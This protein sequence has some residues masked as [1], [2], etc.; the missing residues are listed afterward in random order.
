VKLAERVVA[1]HLQAG[2]KGVN[3]MPDD[4]YIQVL[5]YGT[6]VEFVLKD[7]KAPKNREIGHVRIRPVGGCDGALEAMNIAAKHGWGPFLHDIALEYAGER[8]VVPDRGSVTPEAQRLYQVYQKRGDI[9]KYYLPEMYDENECGGYYEDYWSG[10]GDY[11]ILD[12][13]YVKKT[14]TT[15]PKLKQLGKWRKS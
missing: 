9:L 12:Y 13:K 15:I 10:G 6:G 11:N 1:R 7:A 3:D 4:W 5:K 2:A 8:G 14:K